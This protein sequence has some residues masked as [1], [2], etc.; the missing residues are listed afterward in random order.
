MLLSWKKIVF[1]G[2]KSKSAG[3]GMEMKSRDEKNGE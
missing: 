1:F 2:A 3:T